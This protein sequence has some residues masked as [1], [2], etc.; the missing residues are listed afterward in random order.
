MNKIFYGFGR[1]YL[2]LLDYGEYNEE[3]YHGQNES[4]ADIMYVGISKIT[5]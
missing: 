5:R 3:N 2:K 1:D 4:D